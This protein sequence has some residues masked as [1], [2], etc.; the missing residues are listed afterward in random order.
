MSRAYGR[1]MDGAREPSADTGV[2]TRLTIRRGVVMSDVW[3][4]G[5][6]QADPAHGRIAWTSPLA[7]A[8]AGAERGEVIE[9]EAGGLTE[10]I[11]VLAVRSDDG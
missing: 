9:M 8:L 5:E 10:E 2:G 7:R 3:I 6:E 1:E 4:V 11:R